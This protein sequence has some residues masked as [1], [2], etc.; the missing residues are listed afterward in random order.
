MKVLVIF[1]SKDVR[2][3]VGFCL[4]SRFQ[5][6]VTDFSATGDAIAQYFEKNKQAPDLIICDSPINSKALLEYLNAQKLKYSCILCVPDPK[7]SKD[8]A[9]PGAFIAAPGTLLSKAEELVQEFLN[10]M[11]VEEVA[12]QGPFIAIRTNLLLNTNPLETDLYLQLTEGKF[13]KIMN[14]G[15]VF[16]EADFNKYGEKKKIDFL[17]IPRTGLGV[18]IER[19]NFEITRILSGAVDGVSANTTAVAI[20]ETAQELLKVLGP[21]SE[22]QDLIKKNTQLSMHVIGKNPK[23]KQVLSKLFFDR[24]RYIASH[25]VCLAQVSCTLAAAME[26]HSESTFHKLNLAAFLHDITLPSEKLAAVTSMRDLYDKKVLFTQEEMDAYKNHPITAAELAQKFEEVPP[27]VDTLIVQHH[28]QS[29][30]NG[31]PRG[32]QHTH[33]GPLSAVFIVSHELVDWIFDHPG[34]L[35]IEAFLNAVRDRYDVGHFKK[36]LKVLEHIPF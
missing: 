13:I 23:L 34:G 14:R 36:V 30:G 19:F 25:S 20:Q 9:G 2:Q 22:V 7:K 26:W 31:F 12:D 29:D 32:L 11:K 27:D 5:A 28:E 21:K 15:D 16:E 33:I 24:E 3:M 17:F 18:V 6:Q 1:L 10:K 4:Q 35:K 8:A